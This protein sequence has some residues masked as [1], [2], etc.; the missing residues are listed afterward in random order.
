MHGIYRGAIVVKP[1]IDSDAEPNASKR[2]QGLITDYFDKSSRHQAREAK[3][4]AAEEAFL[5]AVE[6][7]EAAE[8]AFLDA[9]EDMALAD[10]KSRPASPSWDGEP[11]PDDKGTP[12]EHTPGLS[13]ARARGMHPYGKPFAPLC[14]MS[15]RHGRKGTVD[16]FE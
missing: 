1:G 6:E 3:V 12:P 11:L 4:T 14:F 10:R 2:S 7:Q 8:Q 13:G 15:G 9:V 5:A 16:C